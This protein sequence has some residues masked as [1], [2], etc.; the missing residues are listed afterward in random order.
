MQNEV[1]E[2]EDLSGRYTM[3]A[4]VPDMSEESFGAPM[5]KIH[6]ESTRMDSPV[7]LAKNPARGTLLWFCRHPV[8][9][10]PVREYSAAGKTARKYL[11]IFP[12]SQS[13]R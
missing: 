4:A 7:L 1:S 6:S 10:H 11:R 12:I 13:R 3:E 2:A 5:P 9:L 8:V